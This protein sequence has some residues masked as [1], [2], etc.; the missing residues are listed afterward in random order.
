MKTSIYCIFLFII[1][2]GIS[3]FFTLFFVT[4]YTTTSY[5]TKNSNSESSLISYT[6]DN[7]RHHY[8]Q[9]T[10]NTFTKTTKNNTVNSPSTFVPSI[11]SIELDFQKNEIINF[12][13][14]EENDFNEDEY[15]DDDIIDIIQLKAKEK[16]IVKKKTSNEVYTTIPSKSY[17]NDDDTNEYK[18]VQ[19]DDDMD[20]HLFHKVSNDIRN[21]KLNNLDI[22]IEKDIYDNEYDEIKDKQELAIEE[23][24][25]KDIEDEIKE[26]NELWS[27]SSEESKTSSITSSYCPNTTY[28]EKC[29][30]YSYI[31]YW[32]TSFTRPQDCFNS[33][34][35]KKFINL[36]TNPQEMKFVIFRPDEGGWNNIRMAAETAIMF[37][38]I[39]GRILVMPPNEKFYLLVSYYSD[40]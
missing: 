15:E 34:L 37:C 29:P 39:T 19:Q 26:M 17:M 36:Q 4:T 24:D 21:I 31:R 10:I 12:L 2:I 38:I 32:K 23:E 33:P 1:I 8:K 9:N 16:N 27:L 25:V 6:K 13:L 40:S 28:T 35:R 22:E 3:I 20:S 14:N 7:L 30:I 5:Q 18:Y 11:S